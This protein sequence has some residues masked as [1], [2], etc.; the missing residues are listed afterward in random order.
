ML[1]PDD[2]D[3]AQDVAP[4][5]HRRRLVNRHPADLGRLVD[6]RFTNAL[7]PAG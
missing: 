2:G 5:D 4:G 7:G 3:R 6:L 1:H